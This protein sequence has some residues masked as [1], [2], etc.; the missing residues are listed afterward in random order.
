MKKVLSIFALALALVACTDKPQWEPAT[1][2]QPLTTSLT[3]DTAKS[4]ASNSLNRATIYHI[5]GSVINSVLS[6]GVVI[7]SG[8]LVKDSVIMEDVVVKSGAKVYSAIIDS[9]TTVES[10]AVV[11]TENADKSDIAIVAKGTTVRAS[12]KR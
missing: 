10:K 8:A 6:G 7:E 3:L 5:N 1:P 9:D 12:K 4:F 11:G 2:S